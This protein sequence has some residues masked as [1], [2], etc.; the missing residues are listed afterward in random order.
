[1]LFRSTSCALNSP[2]GIAFDP[3]GDMFVTDS[4][5]RVL[6]VPATHSATNPTTQVPLTGLV[7]PTGVILDGSGNIYVSDLNGTVN[8]LLVNTGALKFPSLNS[9]LTT[10]VT[11]TGNSS[12]NITSLNLANGGGSAFSITGNTCTTAVP[13]GG[14]CTITLTYSNAAGAATDTL[15]ITSNAFSLSGVTIQLSH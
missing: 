1:M 14:T 8:E 5:A 15:T 7:N 9:S 2:A 12:L 11:N 4:G 6:M 3:N 13:P 10:T